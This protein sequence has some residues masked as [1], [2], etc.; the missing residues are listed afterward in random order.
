MK[1]ELSLTAN[2]LRIILLVTVILLTTGGVA[3][4]IVAQGT[5]QKFAASISQTEVDAAAVDGNIAKFKQLETTLKNTQ[6]IKNKADSIAIPA[7]DYPV[8][9]IANITNIAKESNVDIQSIGYGDNTTTGAAA[10]SGTTPTPTPTTSTPTTLPN[11]API[12]GNTTPQSTSAKKT[13]NVTLKSPLDYTSLM[14]FIKRIENN[15]TYLHI[16]SISLT[17]AEANS[18]TVLPFTIEVYTR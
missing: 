4:F 1:L 6:D 8:A 9:V 7:S 12:P 11:G 18:V 15:S 3:G 17:K 13:V 16:T 14:S 2:V 5:L 10:S